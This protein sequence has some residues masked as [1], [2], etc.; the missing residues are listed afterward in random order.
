MFDFIFVLCCKDTTKSNNYQIFKE[1]SYYIVYCL[2]FL[3]RKIKYCYL[4]T[5][6]LLCYCYYI[7][8]VSYYIIYLIIYRERTKAN[9]KGR[10][11]PRRSAILPASSSSSSPPSGG[12]GR[13]EQTSKQNRKR[14]NQGEGCRRH[15]RP[16]LASLLSCLLSSPSTPSPKGRAATPS[17]SGRCHR[18]HLAT[19]R[20]R[21]TSSHQTAGQ[22]LGLSGILPASSSSPSSSPPSGGEGRAASQPGRAI[23]SR[24]PC[25]PS[26]PCRGVP[27]HIGGHLRRGAGVVST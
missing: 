10:A 27:R 19:P 17:G 4:F 2:T 18:H 13:E 1:K 20:H 24:S 26:P 22:R 12:E 7:L 16:F 6:Y 9:G 3:N 8:Y 5:Y 21:S 15:L 11:A 25:R 14:E 23:P